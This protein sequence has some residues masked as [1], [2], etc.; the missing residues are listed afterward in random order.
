MNRIFSCDMIFLRPEIMCKCTE[1]YVEYLNLITNMT[2]QHN[3]ID[4][5]DQMPQTVAQST[6]TKKLASIELNGSC[7]VLD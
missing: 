6:T 3:W 5:P 4:E 7:N 2:K 1:I